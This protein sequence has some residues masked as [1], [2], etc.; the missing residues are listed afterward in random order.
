LPVSTSGNLPVL[1][2]LSKIPYPSDK[3]LAFDTFL[4]F[5]KIAAAPL[6]VLNNPNGLASPDPP[7]TS[8]IPGIIPPGPRILLLPPPK[9]LNGPGVV[10]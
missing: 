3:I 10:S 2:T 4:A 1:A 5:L 7:N 6:A 9:I 8:P